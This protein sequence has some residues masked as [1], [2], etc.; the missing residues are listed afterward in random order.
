MRGN[1]KLGLFLLLVVIVVIAVIQAGQKE[2]IDW[3]KTYN[4]K[5]KIPFGT[6]VVRQELQHIFPKNKEIEE[7]NESLYSFF[8]DS[9]RV[10][11][12]REELF[13]IG[14]YF[15]PGRAALK[16]L[17]NFVEKGN[18]VFLA[19]SYIPDTL[20]SRL[21]ISATEFDAYE[22]D[23]SFYYEN[24]VYELAA[25]G[26]QARYDRPTESFFFD[27]L[28]STATILGHLVYK[29]RKFPNFIK[30]PFGEGVFYFQLDPSIYAN[31]YMLKLENFDLAYI[32][33]RHLEGVHLRWYDGLYN[34]TAETSPLRVILGHPALQW[35][36][37]ILLLAL[38][39]Y[40]VFKSR[41]EQGAIPIVEPEKNQSVAFAETIGSLYYENGSPGDML[42]K[43]IEYFRY[44]FKKEF[45]LQEFQPEELEWRKQIALRLGM[46]EKEIT[47]FFR[48]LRKYEETKGSAQDLVHLQ[49]VIEDFKQKIKNYE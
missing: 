46:P 32:S 37:Y 41:R 23:G 21:H 29:D 25:T 24:P 12:T 18:T 3:R 14:D 33:L 40:L 48:S 13:F 36:W 45:H 2:P 10:K 43:K 31:Y 19:T 39:L 42:Q 38:L 15:S 7:I 6:Y 47:D 4:P 35:A 17:M 26:I 49:G 28:D 1:V 16:E 22:V 30:V 9:M 44:S 11:Q 8:T 27:S 5:D 34:A 20:A